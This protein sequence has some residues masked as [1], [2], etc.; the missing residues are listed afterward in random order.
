MLFEFGYT[1]SFEGIENLTQNSEFALIAKYLA[2]SI[3]ELVPNKISV[4]RIE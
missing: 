4:V 3:T 2:L 1:N